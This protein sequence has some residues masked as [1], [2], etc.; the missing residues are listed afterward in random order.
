MGRETLVVTSA[1]GPDGRPGFVLLAGRA[2]PGT[3][4]KGS[5]EDLQDHR[6]ALASGA[7]SGAWCQVRTSG[8]SATGGA[9]CSAGVVATSL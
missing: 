9:A 5:G 4:D 2:V 7:R 3:R 8:Q 6:C 1:T